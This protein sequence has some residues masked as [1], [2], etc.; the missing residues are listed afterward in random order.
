M[1]TRSAELA[2]LLLRR[3]ARHAAHALCCLA[4][5][6]PVGATL[7][8]DA[9]PPRVGLVTMAPGSEYWARFGHNAILIDDGVDPLLYNYGY[10]D[11]E[12]QDF[13]LRFLRGRMAYRLLAIPLQDDLRGYAA[14][15]RRVTV[16]WLDLA[17]EQIR[18][19]DA[20]LRDNAREENAEYRY[21]YFTANCSTKVRDALDLALDGAL[22]RD[23]SGRSHGYTYRDEA[24][25]LAAPVPWLG[26]GIHLGLGPFVDRRMSLWDESY[27]PERLHDAVGEM[28]TGSGARLVQS[29]QEL[30]PAQRPAA[31]DAPPAWRAAFI[32]AGLA[33]AGLAAWGVRPEPTR[34]WRGLVAAGVG[35]FWLVCGLTGVGLLALWV[36]TDHVAAWGNENALLFN[37]LCLALLPTAWRMARGQGPGRGAVRL[38]FGIATCAALALF[39]KF[40][41]FR[42]QSNGDWIAL[43]LPLHAVLAW[44]LGRRIPRA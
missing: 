40:L 24:L 35:A 23:L 32:L 38:A 14:D 2:P 19:L 28:R 34:R 22:K 6:L 9:P 37:P 36:G 1:P 26:L 18:V 12:Q 17:P 21:D 30:L 29:E 39:L 41:P 15:G 43:L 8:Q 33:A 11:F 31:P 16:Q 10:F 4:L 25:R 13:L 5:W 20:F 42:I 27:V 3:L 44:R 7:A